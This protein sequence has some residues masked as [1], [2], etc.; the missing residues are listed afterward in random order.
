MRCL[1]LLI[2]RSKRVIAFADG[3][4]SFIS[5]QLVAEAEERVERS[6]TNCSLGVRLWNKSDTQSGD[7]WARDLNGCLRI[8][9]RNGT[10]WTGFHCKNA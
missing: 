5:V 6:D 2:E 3:T 1:R 7:N 8:A 10:L 4:D 9:A